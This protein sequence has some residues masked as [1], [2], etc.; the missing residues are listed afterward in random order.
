VTSSG[1]LLLEWDLPESS[2]WRWRKVIDVTRSAGIFNLEF[3]QREDGTKL[4][5]IILTN[6]LS[7][8]PGQ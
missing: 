7:F 3:R 5:Q 4:D 8:V 1:S 6:D 2:S